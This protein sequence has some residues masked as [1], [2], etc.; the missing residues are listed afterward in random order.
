[1]SALVN[2]NGKRVT[3]QNEIVEEVKNVYE[4][5]YQSKER[6]LLDIDI[7]DFQKIINAKLTDEEAEDIEGE[8]SRNE[9]S[10]CLKNMKNNT[11]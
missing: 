7:D 9:L 10:E 3:I 8:I 2:S 11:T 5:L 4:T 6:E 1:M